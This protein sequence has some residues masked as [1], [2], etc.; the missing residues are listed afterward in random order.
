MGRENGKTKIRRNR[1]TDTHT[2]TQRE[3]QTN[4]ER[5]KNEWI[6]NGSVTNRYKGMKQLREIV[7]KGEAEVEIDINRAREWHRDR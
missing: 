5:S 4:K 6:G 1:A 3:R 7:R 2:H